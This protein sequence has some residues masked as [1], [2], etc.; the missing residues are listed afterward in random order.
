MSIHEMQNIHI[1]HAVYHVVLYMAVCN[2]CIQPH[3][4]TFSDDCSHT[5]TLLMNPKHV[6]G[7]ET[8]VSA[9]Y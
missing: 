8:H 7:N 6:Y 4:L 9:G 5:V 2:E 1:Q 3:S